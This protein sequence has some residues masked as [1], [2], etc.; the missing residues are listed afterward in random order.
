M[1]WVKL[2]VC[3][4]WISLD[5]SEGT[6]HI[7]SGNKVR[8]NTSIA[9]VTIFLSHPLNFWNYL[10]VAACVLSCQKPKVLFLTFKLWIQAEKLCI[11]SDAKQRSWKVDPG[12]CLSIWQTA[13]GAFV[14]TTFWASQRAACIYCQGPGKV[15]WVFRSSFIP[16]WPQSYLILTML[17][18]NG[19]SECWRVWTRCAWSSV[20]ASPNLGVRMSSRNLSVSPSF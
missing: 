19:R 20:K 16:L 13:S 10:S 14:G 18:V 12:K 9:P 17:R 15:L 1:N 7:W 3:R 2:D 5:I 6:G 4:K 8:T 11:P